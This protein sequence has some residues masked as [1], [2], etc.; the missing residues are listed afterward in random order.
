MLLVA[1]P[2]SRIFAEARYDVLAIQLGSWRCA[3][4]GNEAPHEIDKGAA[5]LHYA[6][7]APCLTTAI[8]AMFGPN[9]QRGSLLHLYKESAR[10]CQRP[11]NYTKNW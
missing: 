9:G 2:C 10:E 11:L 7:E 8:R 1:K 6:G 5:S 3:R 4:T